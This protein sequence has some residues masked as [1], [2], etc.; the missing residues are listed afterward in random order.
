MA[1]EPHIKVILTL[2]PYGTNE[3]QIDMELQLYPDNE[4]ETVTSIGD[5]IGFFKLR[6]RGKDLTE[7]IPASARFFW[8]GKG[9][10]L[11]P[12]NVMTIIRTATQMIK[13]LRAE[14]KQTSDIKFKHMVFEPGFND[15]TIATIITFIRNMWPSNYDILVEQEYP[16][17]NIVHV[18][19]EDDKLKNWDP[20]TYFWVAWARNPKMYGHGTSLPRA[21]PRKEPERRKDDDCVLL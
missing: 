4:R 6:S 10:E 15:E 12:F 21:V 16:G 1:T 11:Y 13:S 14:T 19:G 5:A 3:E 9:F 20:P 2:F 8:M 18:V 7:Q 17:E